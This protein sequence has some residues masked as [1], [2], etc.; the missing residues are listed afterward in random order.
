MPVNPLPSNPNLDHL[1]AQAKDLLK[2]RASREPQ[3]AQRIRE[4]HPRFQQCTDTTIFDSRFLLSDALLTIAR[5]RGFASWARLKRHIE[6]PTLADKLDLPHHE[7]I[8][9]LAFRQAVDLLDRGDVVGLRAHLHRQPHLVRER[10]LFEG[11]NYFRNPTL[12]EFVAENPVRRGTLPGNIVEVAKVILE[13]GAKADQTSLNDALGLVSSGCVPRE[14]HVQIPLID[15]LCAYGADPTSAL[16]TALAHGELEAAE[17]MLRNGARI[18][19]VIAAGLGRVEDFR[20]L[21]S[22][23]TSEERHRAL[24]LA[25]MYGH[26]DIVGLLLD[27]GEDPNRYNPVGFHAHST[28]LHQAAAY[29]HYEVVRLLVERGARLDMKD[30]TPGQGTPAGWARH[31]GHKEIE[32]YLQAQEALGRNRLQPD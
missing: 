18:D 2:A 25:S 12:L 19:L 11:G 14:C 9:N 30:T 27:V 4:F 28:P 21:L 1:K 10:V 13:A 3:A 24:V 17:A 23:S 5:E 16:L 31:E 22:T 6:K 7:R 29:G 26:A 20:R 8:E 32:E 15:L